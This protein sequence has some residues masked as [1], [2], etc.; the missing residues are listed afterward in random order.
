MCRIR[1]PLTRAINKNNNFY[2]STQCSN[3]N[4]P[5]DKETEGHRPQTIFFAQRP[6]PILPHAEPET[7]H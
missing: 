3:N 2:C 5:S 4:N 7:W 1:V 6:R